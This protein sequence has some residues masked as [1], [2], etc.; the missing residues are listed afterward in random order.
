MHM[1][2]RWERINSVKT[3]KPKT[4][5][6]TTIH[7]APPAYLLFTQTLRLSDKIFKQL[8]EEDGT[9]MITTKDA[10]ADSI[11]A[12]QLYNSKSHLIVP[13]EFTKVAAPVAEV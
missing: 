6:K 7:N 9:W 10:K 13:T 11:T 4:K 2:V 12:E 1:H 3:N 8:K 5:T